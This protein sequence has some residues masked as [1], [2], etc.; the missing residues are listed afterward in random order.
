MKTILSVLVLTAVAV[1]GQPEPP[2]C[3]TVDPVVCD[4]GELQCK[5][6]LDFNDCPLK[7]FC[8]APTGK[9]IWWQPETKQ[10]ITCHYL[11]FAFQPTK[12]GMDHSVSTIAPVW[13]MRG[14]AAVLRSTTTAACPD[15]CASQERVS[16][17]HFLL[18]TYSLSTHSPVNGCDT[19]CARSEPCPA[20]TTKCPPFVEN[21]CPKGSDYCSPRM[22]YTFNNNK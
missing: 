7:D 2:Q 12:P 3:T 5:M 19:F 4:N 13:L 16:I 22:T 8:M 17:K 11:L 18:T 15:Q 20:G 6:G 10:L 14:N 21:G 9:V 1:H